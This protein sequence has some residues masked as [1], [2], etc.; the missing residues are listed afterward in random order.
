MWAFFGPYRADASPV[1]LAARTPDGRVERHGPVTAGG[2]GTGFHVPAVEAR[3]DIIRRRA[4][5]AVTDSLFSNGRYSFW[6]PRLPVQQPG[7]TA[8]PAG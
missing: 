8:T 7:G 6:N 1:Q 3:P 2:P 5:A 4:A